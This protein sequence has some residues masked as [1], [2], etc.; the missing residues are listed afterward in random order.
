[1]PLFSLVFLV[2][3]FFGLKALAFV[4]FE[5]MRTKWVAVTTS[6]HVCVR[7]VS[8]TCEHGS[9]SWGGGL[10]PSPHSAVERHLRRLYKRTRTVVYNSCT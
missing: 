3:M 1:M 6:C 5:A 8:S 9:G 2:L 7:D 10:S 4:G